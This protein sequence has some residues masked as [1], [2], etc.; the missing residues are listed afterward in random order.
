[1]N[2]SQ[3]KIAAYNTEFNHLYYIHFA[4]YDFASMA[5]ILVDNHFIKYHEILEEWKLK[6]GKNL[7]FVFQIIP[8][9][10]FRWGL[11]NSENIKP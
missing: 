8:S 2:A 7:C 3:P 11:E 4:Y 9:L 6:K 1:M 10:V 5:I